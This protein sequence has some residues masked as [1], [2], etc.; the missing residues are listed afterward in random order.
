MKIRGVAHRG[1]RRFIERNDA[2]GL[3]PAV[4]EK[5]RNIL[6]FLQDMENVQELRNVPGWKVHQLG[7]GRK[8]AW[9]IYVTRKLADH[10]S[11]RS[12]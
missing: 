5:I 1:L 9:S 11:D 10:V 6:T 7:G 4:V 2:S 12:D 8:G 3:S